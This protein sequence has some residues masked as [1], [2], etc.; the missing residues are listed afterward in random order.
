LSYA[1]VSADTAGSKYFGV[2]VGGQLTVQTAAVDP[3]NLTSIIISLY[4]EDY[5]YPGN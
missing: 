4:Y 3:N 1:L 2:P 5:R